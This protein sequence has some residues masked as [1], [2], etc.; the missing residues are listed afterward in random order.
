MNATPAASDEASRLRALI[1]TAFRGVELGKG[2]SIRQSEAIDLDGGANAFGKDAPQEVTD[3]WTR[4]PIEELERVCVPYL[5][6]AGFRFYIPALMLSVL[7]HYDPLSMRV[8]GTI[9]SLYPKQDLWSFHM[10]QYALLDAAQLRAIATYV[11]ALPALV[12]LHD[13]EHAMM[14]RAMRN[15]W[16]QY[17][18]R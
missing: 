1:T 4:V 8:T 10:D 9:G 16:G 2:I 14:S 12:P 15:F 6:A 7:S 3:D 17:Q 11:H 5:D 13:E 18:A